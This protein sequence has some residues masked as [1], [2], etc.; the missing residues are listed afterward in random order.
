MKRRNPIAIAVIAVSLIAPSVVFAA[1]ASIHS[2]VNAM[3]SKTKTIK[4]T[5]R[6]DSS[7]PMELKVGDE[8]VTLDAGKSLE[9]RLPAGARVLANAA[10]ALHQPGSV[11][12]EVSDSLSGAIIHI[13]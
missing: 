8:V 3:F 7:S 1:P 5:L 9:V 4:F 13:K 12:A 6:N 10:T 2:P 11:I